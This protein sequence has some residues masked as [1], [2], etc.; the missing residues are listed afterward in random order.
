MASKFQAMRLFVFCVMCIALCGCDAS[1]TN[2]SGTVCERQGDLRVQIGSRVFQ[3]PRNDVTHILDDEDVRF[4]EDS[5]SR[6]A[7]DGVYV[8]QGK[9]DPPIEL[10]YVGLQTTIEPLVCDEMCQEYP[11]THTGNQLKGGIVPFNETENSFKEKQEKLHKKCVENPY[12][13]TCDYLVRYEDT[14]FGFRF[15]LRSFPLEKMNELETLITDYLTA[16]DITKLVEE[17]KQ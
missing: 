15:Y 7:N 16:H 17:G 13:N 10:K 11:H 4:S 9:N 1:D 14:K 3:F 2:A 8:C 5:N 12:F 6:W